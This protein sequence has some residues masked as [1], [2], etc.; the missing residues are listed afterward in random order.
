VT[1]DLVLPELN[2]EWDKLSDKGYQ[3]QSEDRAKIFAALGGTQGL[4]D[5]GIPSIVFLIDYD[6]SHKLNQAIIYSLLPTILFFFW[7]LLKRETIQYAL[8]GV[9]GVA[10]CALFAHFSHKAT[11]FYL[12]SLIKNAA[13]AAL[14]LLTNLAG[15]PLI[16]VIIGP[17]IGENMN[18]RNVKAR[19]RAYQNV[20]W[21]WAGMFLIRIAVMYP[22]Y[23]ANKLNAL[24]AASFILSYPLYFLVL[25]LSW[26][27]LRQTPPA[28]II[29][30]NLTDQNK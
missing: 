22:L 5:S 1:V 7:R 13:F 20:G 25:W 3:G 30:T 8:S 16:G 21:I 10:I 4:I 23:K 19:K 15:W 6:I 26:V 11:G 17:L 2:R 18:W 9:F 29:T 27:I 12:P 28:K 24:G 14:Y